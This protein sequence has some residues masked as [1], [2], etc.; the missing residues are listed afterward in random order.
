MGNFGEKIG[1]LGGKWAILGENGQIWGEI[2]DLE[3]KWEIWGQNGKF[4]GGNG[5]FGGKM[6]S[7][8]PPFGV[9]PPSLGSQTPYFWCRNPLF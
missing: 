6:A 3:G 5:K 2:G 9:I 4:R 8:K 7:L 1:N